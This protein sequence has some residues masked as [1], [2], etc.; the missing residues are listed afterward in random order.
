MHNIKIMKTKHTSITLLIL[1][2]LISITS[3]AQVAPLMTTTWDQ[4][5]YYNDDVPADAA[6]PCGKAWTGCKATAIA[7]IM[8]Y[9]QHPTNGWGS[10]T[11]SSSYGSLSA[12]FSTANFDW[13]SMPDNLSSA[14]SEVAKLM[15][16]VGVSTDM[17]YGP[18]ASNAFF[19]VQLLKQNFKYSLSAT[20]AP[21]DITDTEKEDLFISELAAGRVVFVRAIWGNHFYV[22]DGYQTSPLEFHCNFGWGGAYNGYYDLHNIDLIGH[23]L[24]PAGVIYG[25]KPLEDIEVTDSVSISSYAGSGSFELS[26][27]NAWTVTSDQGWATPNLTSGGEG[28]YNYLNGMLVNVTENISYVPRVAT[29]T[30]DDGSVT[31]TLTVT[32]QGVTPQLSLGY[33]ES[34]ITY[35]SVGGSETVT[36]TT[37]SNWVAS[38][39]DAWLSMVPAS[40]SG[41]GTFDLTAIA[42][43]TAATRFGTVTVI[44]GSLQQVISVTQGGNGSTWCTPIMTTPNDFG[45]TNVTLNTINR[46]SV[47]DEGY[48]ETTD[49]TLLFLDS[50]YSL[51]VTFDG[52]NAPEVWI[53]WNQDGDFSDASE[54]ITNYSWYPTFDATKSIDV[55]VPSG[56]MEG[57]TRMRVYSKPFGSGP[58][59]SPCGTTDAGGD[60]E[61]Y[62]INVKSSKYLDV[63]PVVVNYLSSADSSFVNIQCDSIWTSTTTVGWLNL[64]AASGSGDGSIQMVATAN[65]STLPRS[66]S[67]T[68]TRGSYEEIIGVYQAGEDSVISISP[69]TIFA[70]STGG[71][72]SFNISSNIDYTVVSDQSWLT[73]SIS[74]GSG[75]ESPT[76]VYTLNPSNTIRIATVIASQDG[77]ADTLVFVQDLT[78]TALSATPTTLNF[79]GPGVIAQNVSVTTLSSWNASASDSWIKLDVLSG[80]GDATIAIECD[81]NYTGASRA[82]SITITNGV[83]SEVITVSQIHIITTG[84]SNEFGD[85]QVRIYPSPTT[86]FVNV[87]L[88]SLTNVSVKVYNE[89]GQLVLRQDNVNSSMHQF[90]LNGAT[91]V[92]FVEV[93]SEGA[94]RRFKL[95]KE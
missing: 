52:A 17:I 88:G 7:Q 62:T 3:I 46:T 51:S 33:G 29:L 27:L 1:G 73:P 20:G 47:F 72:E 64:S 91:G 70:V 14:N 48:I 35:S 37:D 81:S 59:A 9:H 69:D 68:F 15:Y 2:T 36:I 61:D 26:S 78:S 79:T 74:T 86:G 34:N 41:D 44:R 89:T 5:C 19:G 38:T 53:D 8:K 50:T 58:V 92:Y 45:V 56:A 21:L 60:I 23:D 80:T 54:N 66:G 84:L 32:Q 31:K 63:T 65:N 10:N 12:D 40:G 87:D 90:N 28:Y 55:I 6:G 11:Y 94:T 75:D 76:L 82:G 43:P 77:I 30:F 49:S 67:V 85:D 71:V 42:N 93:S 25:I 13:A 24:T 83:T 18:S 39:G 57:T 22:V 4:G 16:H 95:I